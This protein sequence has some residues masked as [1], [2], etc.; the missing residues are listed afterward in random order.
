M[1][2]LVSESSILGVSGRLQDLC[3]PVARKH[4]VAIRIV[5]GRNLNAVVVDSQKTAFECVEVPR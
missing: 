2:E 4:D 5:L 3:S 1:I